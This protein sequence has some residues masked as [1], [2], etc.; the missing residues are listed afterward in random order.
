MTNPGGPDGVPDALD[1][2]LEVQGRAGGRRPP[3]T[4]GQPGIVTASLPRLTSA[5]VPSAATGELRRAA[6]GATAVAEGIGYRLLGDRARTDRTLW[7][8]P[9]DAPGGRP[10]ALLVIEQADGSAA[11]VRLPAQIPAERVLPS[12]VVPM[13]SLD[14]ERGLLRET[15]HA[16]GPPVQGAACLVERTH[17]WNGRG[18]EL[19]EERRS[20]ACEGSRAEWR[21]VTFARAFTASA[22]PFAAAAASPFTT[23]CARPSP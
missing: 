20:C 17:G 23:P 22:A 16:P 8:M 3:A 5:V 10:R 1:L 11:P 13:A 21:A 6:C 19:I 7:V 12:G 18:F 9:C 15:W 2:L 14:A 4:G